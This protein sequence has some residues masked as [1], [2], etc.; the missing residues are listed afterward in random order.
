MNRDVT[1][2]KLDGRTYV[3]LPKAEYL[4]LRK[5]DTPAGTV[6]AVA[7]ADTAIARSLRAAREKS[8]LMQE[9]LATKLGKSQTLVSQAEAGKMTVGA[10]YVASVLAACGLPKTW[11]P[12]K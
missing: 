11:K 9:E 7:H 10:R 2:L 3:V 1:E 4:R 5:G 12:G 6:D 8:G